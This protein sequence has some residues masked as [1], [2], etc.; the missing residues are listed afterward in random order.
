VSFT[1]QSV[2]G[3]CCLSTELRIPA[4]SALSVAS[5]VT[6]CICKFLEKH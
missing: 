4:E 6:V 5:F 3:S 1:G 2:T